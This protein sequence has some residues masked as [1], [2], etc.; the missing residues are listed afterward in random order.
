MPVKKRKKWLRAFIWLIS[1][2][3]LLIVGVHLLFITYFDKEVKSELCKEF[4]IQ[5]KGEYE[6]QIDE[7]RTNIFKQSVFIKGFKV[8][9][10]KGLRPDATKIYISADV[11]KLEDFGLKPF[12]FSNSLK[13]QNLELVNPKLT[14]F[15]NNV[16]HQ[17]DVK[18]TSK[19]KFSIY[20][21]LKPHVSSF[22]IKNI[23]VSN[24]E[25]RLYTN[26]KDSLLLLHSSQNSLKIFDLN[27]NEESEK[28][29]RLFLA[30]K[31]DVTI[32]N[33]S[34]TTKNKLY[35]IKVAK[36]FASYSSS[37]VI[38][39]SVQLIPLYSRKQFAAMAGEQ[40]DR[41]E[42]TVS[43]VEF[44]EMDV[45]LF[46]EK[47]WFI[48]RQLNISDAYLGSYRD[49][50]DTRKPAIPQSIQSLIGDIPVNINID[51]ITV[52]NAL[53]V[54]EEV[55]DESTVPGKISFTNI[56]AVVIGFV[57][58]QSG[59]KSNRDMILNLKCRLMDKAKLQVSYRFPFNTTGM[60]FD[61]SGHLS[62]MPFKEI[63]NVIQPLAKVSFLDG[64]IDSM[65]FSFHAGDIASDGIMKMVYHG[66]KVQIINKNDGKRHLSG[67]FLSFL[68][69]KFIL[70]EDNPTKNNPIRV[71]N[72]HYQRD[73]ERFIFNYT[74]KSILSGMKE[75]IGIPDRLKSKKS[76]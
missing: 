24:A 75:T 45:K 63:N 40:T 37:E 76:K 49:K 43:K 57:N 58:R 15:R 39:D 7:L 51:S 52:K 44:K 18:D 38:M 56:D 12:I 28:L 23:L 65:I 71:T 10:I 47:N 20:K 11:I 41:L 8:T 17:P 33:F 46:F 32:R 31:T 42:L 66:M 53:C 14:V 27:I 62:R 35:N 9:P 61:C 6:L 5:S 30:E 73:R 1:L 59:N 21:L 34:Y 25:I 26:E 70:K 64:E 54:Y 74:L 22:N 3:V 4:S 19:D 16:D 72:I 13:F 36:V 29:G 67:N 68:A 48:A 55:A 50:N 2:F 69:N 60:V